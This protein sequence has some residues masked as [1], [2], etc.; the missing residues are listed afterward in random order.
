MA[1]GYALSESYP[2]KNGIPL[3][4]TYKQLQIPSIA[5]APPIQT[6]IIEKAEP[7]GPLGAK[8]IS[9]VATVPLTP[10]ILNAIYNAIGV[11]IYDLPA[12]PEKILAEM[13]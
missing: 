5:Q 2:I 10:A 4:R 8:G 7:G 9:E 11:R 3:A 13:T 12:T 1:Q 6:L